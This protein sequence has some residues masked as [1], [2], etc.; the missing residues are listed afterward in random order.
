MSKYI[1]NRIRELVQIIPHD[2][3]GGVEMRIGNKFICWEVDTVG[4][5]PV[6]A[7][8]IRKTVGAIIRRVIQD[9]AKEADWCKRQ[10]N[11]GA[12]IRKL[13]EDRT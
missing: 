5:L 4:K 8:H 9:C 13:L 10:D 7:E 12:A 3:M 1:D 2:N 6:D 11:A